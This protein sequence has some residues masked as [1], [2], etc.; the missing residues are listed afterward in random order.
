MEGWGSFVVL[1]SGCP[2]HNCNLIT[3]RSLPPR[4]AAQIAAV[5]EFKAAQPNSGLIRYFGLCTT[6]GIIFSSLFTA[7]HWVL[8]FT[9]GSSTGETKKKSVLRGRSQHH[10]WPGWVRGQV[11]M[12]SQRADIHKLLNEPEEKKADLSQEGFVG[13]ANSAP[14]AA[15]NHSPARTR[16]S[17]DFHSAQA[18][19]TLSS[20]VCFLLQYCREP[21]SWYPREKQNKVKKKKTISDPQI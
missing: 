13:F 5:M 12:T 10:G 16:P 17:L 20:N 19:K 14:S 18:D 15:C 8:S 1:L 9:I 4:V 6:H 7:F 3:I 2:A 21:S 11:L